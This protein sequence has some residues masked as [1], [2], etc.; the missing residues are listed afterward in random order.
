MKQVNPRKIHRLIPKLDKKLLGKLI[1]RMK[2]YGWQGRPV[3]VEDWWDGQYHAW[4]GIHRIEA[5]IRVGLESI[6]VVMVDKGFLATKTDVRELSTDI[7]KL[8][9]L[10]KQKEWIAVYYMCGEI[11]GI[12]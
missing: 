12:D 5:A 3:V 11:L 9:W 4:T 2:L 1:Y 6:P 7:E 10:V 8:E